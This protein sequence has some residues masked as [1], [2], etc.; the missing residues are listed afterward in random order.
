[1]LNEL[2]N[3]PKDQWHGLIKKIE[4]LE[5]VGDE[6]THEIFTQLS[7]NFITPFDREDIIHLA[8]AMDDVAD[9]IFASAK[10]LELY[11]IDEQT[12]S[13]RRLGEIIEQSAHELHIAMTEL[14]SVNNYVRVRE[15]LVRINSLE[16]HAD[17]VFNMAIADLFEHE[18]DAIK[19]I[20]Y[21]EIYSNLEIATDKCEDVAN[22]IESIIIKNS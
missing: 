11:K 8:S 4:D 21:Q 12:D 19:V 14:R 16:N 13:M 15:A 20:K 17:D 10:R 3:A 7:A 18:K 1:M 5:H 22:A 6:I 2:F 9:Y